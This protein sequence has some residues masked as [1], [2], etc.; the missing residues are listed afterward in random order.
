MKGKRE[1]DTRKEK[2]SSKKS[3]HLQRARKRGGGGV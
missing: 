2:F 1:K 3:V